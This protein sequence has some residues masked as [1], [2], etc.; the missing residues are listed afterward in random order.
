MR[1]SVFSSTFF[2][3][4]LFAFLPRLP[5]NGF[6]LNQ[7]RFSFFELFDS[8]FEL[9]DS[10]FELFDS[11]FELFDFG[12]SEAFAFGDSEAFAF[13]DSDPFDF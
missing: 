11:F 8:F 1:F 10:F 2:P 5:V 12:D 7:F 13:G 9:F 6:R 3:F 4:D